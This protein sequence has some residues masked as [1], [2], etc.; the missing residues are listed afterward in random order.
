MKKVL[1]LALVGVIAVGTMGMSFA[2]SPFGAAETY[3]R[4][5]NISLDE[6][7]DVRL[8]SGMTFGEL[9]ED[10]GFYDA[11]HEEMLAYKIE[12]LDGLVED[13]YLTQEEADEIISAMES[14]HGASQSIMRGRFNF[15]QGSR[16]YDDNDNYQ[17]GFGG[18]MRRGF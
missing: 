16:N 18:M 12:R 15:G 2:A 10:E 9:A 1:S 8:A 14:C 11:F 7:Y 3:S 4:Y 13:G 6:A 17:R 5:A